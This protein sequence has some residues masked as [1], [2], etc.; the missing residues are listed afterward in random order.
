MVRDAELP[1]AAYLDAARAHLPHE[2]DIAIVQG[3]L[4]FAGVHIADRYLPPEARPVALATLTDV[5][6]DLLDRTDERSAPGLRL[7]AVRGFIDSAADPAELSAW[8]TDGTVPG[9][10]ALDPEL[11]WRTQARL[12]VLGA[13]TPADIDAELASDPSATGQEGAARCRAALPDPRAKEAAWA[14]LFDNDDLSAYLVTATAEGFWHPEQ[15]DLLRD[16][17][18]RFY[19][20]AVAASTRRGAAIAEALGRYAFPA[21]VVDAESLRLGEQ[22]LRQPDIVPALRRRLADQLDDLRRAL[23]VRG[24]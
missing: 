12:C 2:N 11:R 22:C 3:V 24:S 17:V 5:C 15:L 1:A 7:T 10:P 21:H 6:R 14:D 8:L 4:A 16:Y 9:G 20:A 18:P 23:H 13:A 19:P